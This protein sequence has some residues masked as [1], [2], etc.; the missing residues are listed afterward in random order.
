MH[1]LFDE[2]SRY[3]GVPADGCDGQTARE[4]EKQLAWLKENIPGRTAERAFGL[5]T[6][7][8]GVVIGGEAFVSRDLGRHLNGCERVILFAATLGAEADRRLKALGA[9]SV[10]SAAVFDACASAYIEQV[11]DEACQKLA[12]DFQAEG[13]TLTSRF[14][15]GYGDLPLETQEVFLRLLPAGRRIGLTLSP[16]LMLIPTKSVTAVIGAGKAA[17]PGERL[18]CSGGSC[19][20][21]PRRDACLLYKKRSE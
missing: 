18:G 10:F 1:T 11:C 9:Q 5:H 20:G 6:R 13:L 14:S 19:E 2:A 4:I 17:Y 8:D 15:P 12:Q 16:S 3:L 21:C 7:P